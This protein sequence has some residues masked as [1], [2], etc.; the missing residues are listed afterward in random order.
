MWG[1]NFLMFPLRVS[2]RNMYVSFRMCMHSNSQSHDDALHRQ[3]MI[4]LLS[5]NFYG[6]FT[7]TE[8]Q[9]VSNV[10]FFVAE[11]Y[12]FSSICDSHSQEGVRESIILL[13]SIIYCLLKGVGR[14]KLRLIIFRKF[15]LLHWVQMWGLWGRWVMPW[16]CEFTAAPPPNEWAN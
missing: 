3:W 1:A 13:T 5:L 4:N 12:W 15:S 10:H 9:F 11:C 7:T 16:W 2:E 8:C 14:M 6:N